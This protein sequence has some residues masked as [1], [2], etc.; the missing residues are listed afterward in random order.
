MANT[1]LQQLITQARQAGWAQITK[2]GAFAGA[3][4]SAALGA[5]N[6]QVV[7]TR[8][9]DETESELAPVRVESARP[10]SISAKVGLGAQ[11]LHTDGAHM[12]RPPHWVLLWSALPSK[13]ATRVWRPRD[14]QV[15]L[16]RTGVFLVGMGANARY[17]NAID[18]AG[19]LRFD[20]GCMRPAD[21]VARELAAVLSAPPASEII[22]LS[23]SDPETYVMIRNDMVLHGRAAVVDGDEGRRIHRLAAVERE[24]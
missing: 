6:L 3:D 2:A 13:T 14:A 20:A 24:S 10:S 4:L 12:T 1:L 5:L 9:G 18:S 21:P 23:W 15:R 19:R 17:A 22:D 7:A 8:A 11:P 16:N